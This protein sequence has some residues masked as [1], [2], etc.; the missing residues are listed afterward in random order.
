M[1]FVLILMFMYM[2]A[3]LLVTPS[4]GD[5]ENSK[6]GDDSGEDECGVYVLGKKRPHFVVV[7]SCSTGWSDV[8]WNYPAVHTPNMESLARE[9]VILNQTYVQ[10][11]CSPSRAAFLTGYY[12]FRLGF[13][14]ATIFP[15]QPAYLRRNFTTI[16][17]AL[18]PLGYSTHI[19]GK[20]HLGSCRWDVTPTYRG[21]DSFLG[22]HEYYTNYET[23]TTNFPMISL[24]DEC[25]GNITNAL[26]AKG[27]W[28]NTVF[29]YLS[30]HATFVT[31]GVSWP[32]RGGAGTTFDGALRS[33]AFISGKLLEKTGYVNNEVI[34]ITDFFPTFLKLAGGTPDPKL[35]GMNIWD[36]LS[37]GSPTPRKET[38]QHLDVY[39]D[40]YH[41]VMRVGDYKLMDGQW[42]FF[43]RLDNTGDAYLTEALDT[44]IPP[45]DLENPDI[46]NVPAAPYNTTL[47]FNIAEDPRET[48]DLS[49]SMPEK[50]EELRQAAQK[51]IETA[52]PTFWPDL[53]Y[54][55]G[56]PGNRGGV[57]SPGWC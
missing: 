35:D 14:R 26:K 27:M 32:F 11:L 42:N 45:I 41:Y 16:A 28:E 20:W 55:S 8:S 39:P 49:A 51:Y 47:L 56:N 21:F 34:H 23:H 46:P 30:D 9:G 43:Y 53:D 3:V 12:A 25:I 33:P 37:K 50:V 4:N 54:E 6:E 5:D 13:G 38:V 29:L 22:T 2:F 24:L 17:E 31:S 15:Q 57:W 36:T 44:W 52:P 1:K 19:L 40:S 18:K 10:Q 7:M 48:T